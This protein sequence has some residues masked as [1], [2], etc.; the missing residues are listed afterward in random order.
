[1]R[2]I[3]NSIKSNLKPLFN[4]MSDQRVAAITGQAVARVAEMR[5]HLP[6]NRNS[7]VK[8]DP[9]VV[10]NDAEATTIIAHARF[11]ELVRAFLQH[12]IQHGSAVEQSLYTSMSWRDEVSR[13][14]SKRPLVFMG[15]SDLTKLPDGRILGGAAQDWDRVGTDHEHLNSHL[16]LNDF[17]SYDEMMLSALLGVSGSSHFINDGN[18]YNAARPGAPGTFEQRG[19]IVGLVGARFEREDR[20]ESSYILPPVRHPRMHPDLR[21]TW[22][23]FLRIEPPAPDNFNAQAYQARIRL[24]AEMLLFEADRRARIANKK[25]YVYIVG[26]GLGVW[27]VDADQPRLYVDVFAQVIKDLGSQLTELGTLEFAWIDVASANRQNMEAIAASHGVDVLFSKRN[28]AARLP[29]DKAEQLLVLSYAW[30]SNSFPGN[31]YWMGSLTA[32]GDPAAA[33]MSTIAELHNPVINPSFLGRL[34]LLGALVLCVVNY[35][36]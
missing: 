30:D 9:V 18:R 15:G 23:D 6:V 13:L 34:E 27:Q 12:K 11:P 7:I 14:I 35:H 28:P 17:L 22:Q 32:S 21:R 29:A 19:I 10:K 24:S 2:I 33:C 3:S 5:G 1:M 31:E 16:R 26:L 25:A 20:M 8:F 36:K 4:T